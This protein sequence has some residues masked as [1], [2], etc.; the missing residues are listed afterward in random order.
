MELSTLEAELRKR[1]YVLERLIYTGQSVKVYDIKQGE[2]PAVVKDIT[3]PHSM[4]WERAIQ[5]V[6][7]VLTLDHPRIVKIYDYFK[8]FSS[9]QTWQLAIVFERVAKDLMKDIQDRNRN[10]YMWR[11]EELLGLYV[12]LAEGFAYLQERGVVHRDI[13]PQNIL[14]A[15]GHIK[16]T[17]FGTSKDGIVSLLT[18]VKEWTV[19]GTPYF[20]SPEVK[21]AFVERKARVD[22]RVVKSDVYS[23]GLTFLIMAKLES[24]ATLV[25]LQSLSRITTEVTANIVYGDTIKNIIRRM[26]EEDETKRPDFI[27]LLGDLRTLAQPAPA[28]QPQ[29]AAAPADAIGCEHVLSGDPA[30]IAT[31]CHGQL[32][33]QCVKITNEELGLVRY[34]CVYCYRFFHQLTVHLAPQGIA[35]VQ[36]PQEQHSAQTNVAKNK[37]EEQKSSLEPID[38][39]SAVCAECRN[40]HSRA[41]LLPQPGSSK[42]LCQ[43][44]IS[45]Y[46]EYEN[47]RY[48]SVL[49]R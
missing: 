16:I 31:P 28:K 49:G 30:V 27:R 22:H 44:C 38:S 29:V 46:E 42:L 48:G 40:V 5:E 32:C 7:I 37:Q 45:Y 8:Y 35:P 13:K 24:P 18:T 3:Y 12:E 25:S 10:K 17:D 19:T 9:P 20:L 14:I 4:T 21:R 26:L 43:N 23:L 47:F 15:N 36:I 11:P 34:Q 2:L 1:N 6:N 41:L 33:A 39:N